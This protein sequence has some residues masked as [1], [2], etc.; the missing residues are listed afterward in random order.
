M[1]DLNSYSPNSI[2]LVQDDPVISDSLI[3]YL[4]DGEDIS[5]AMFNRLQDLDVIEHIEFYK[6]ELIV[7]SL[8]LKKIYFAK[9]LVTE[10]YKFRVSFS[11]KIIKEVANVNSYSPFIFDISVSE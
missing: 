8:S 3:L 2:S 5:D 7:V 10:P 11:K 9:F 6:K 4:K 1:K